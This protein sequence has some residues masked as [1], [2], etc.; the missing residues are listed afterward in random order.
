MIIPLVILP[1]LLAAVGSRAQTGSAG[2]DIFILAGQSN[3]AG[4]GGVAGGKWDGSVPPECQPNPAILR[5]SAQQQWEPAHEPLHAD[6]DVGKTCGVGPGMSFANATLSGGSRIGSVGL[7]PCA[8]GGT[9][10]ARWARG[11][12]LYNRMVGRAKAAL[13][14]G[15][16]IRALL[17]YQGES[18]TV[19]LGDADSYRGHMEDLIR[20]VRSDLGLQDLPVIQVALASGEGSYVEKVRAAQLGISLPGVVTVDAKGLSLGQD[21]LHLTT[22]AQVQWAPSQQRA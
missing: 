12:D 14:E 1:L 2:K 18:D 16:T 4:R 7:V 5:F 9:K 22:S 21:H 3:M 10:I 6:I 17:W 20:N 8:V 11:S 15:G 13:G 19:V